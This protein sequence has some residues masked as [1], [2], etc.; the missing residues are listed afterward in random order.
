MRR[1][2]KQLFGSTAAAC[3]A[4]WQPLVRT[5][6]QQQAYARWVEQRV[7][8]N[9]MGPFFKAYHFQKTNVRGRGLRVQL[10]S[11]GGRQGALF[12]YDPSIGSNFQ[13][14]FD[15]IRDRVLALG[16][17]LSTSDRRRLPHPEYTETIEKHFLKPTP[18]D[19]P[20]TGR[21]NQRFGNVTVDL[22]RIN[23]QPGFIR[24]VSNPY[25]DTIFAPAHTFDELLDAVFNLP[26]ASATEQ[27]CAQQFLK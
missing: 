4:E 18:G 23:D 9:W 1:F 15:F 17:H 10:L 11:E 22:V 6:V 21:C 8:L 13:H 3:Q 5:N 24:F 12:F 7:Y 14:L 20:D 19:C 16:Y 26:A 2:F 27:A 25:H